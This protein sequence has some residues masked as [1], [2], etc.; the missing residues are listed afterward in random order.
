MQ[1][2]QQ[3][4]TIFTFRICIMLVMLASW[5]SD[6]DNFLLTGLTEESHNTNVVN[7]TITSEEDLIVPWTVHTIQ[8]SKTVIS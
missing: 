6:D 2:Q 3:I 4:L 5:L 1:K 8:G 7:E